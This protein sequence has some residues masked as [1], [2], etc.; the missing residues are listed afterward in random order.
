MM[1]KPY[2]RTI[3]SSTAQPNTPETDAMA[4]V[5]HNVTVYFSNG[6][7]E[8]FIINAECPMTAS[9]KARNAISKRPEFNLN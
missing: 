4:T 7:S 8:D 5:P 1:D 3:S 2:I 6:K 9:D